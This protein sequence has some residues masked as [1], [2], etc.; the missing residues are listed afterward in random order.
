MNISLETFSPDSGSSF[1]FM[2]NPRLSELF[3]WHFH[4]E[5]EIVWIEAEQGTRH[6]GEHVSVFHQCD[7]VC[8][9]GNI[10][11]LNFDYGIKTPYRHYVLHISAHFLQ[12]ALETVPELGQI[13]DLFRRAAYGLA[14]GRATQAQVKPLIE[15]L[16]TRSGFGLMLSVL[17]LLQ[18]LASATDVSLLH[19]SPVLQRTSEK[20]RQRLQAL[21]RFIDEHYARKISLEEAA[22]VCCLSK[23][24]FC[25]YFKKLSQQTFTEFLNQYRVNQAQRLLL[26]GYSISDTCYAAG[27]ESLSYFN[28]VFRKVTGQSPLA[29]RRTHERSA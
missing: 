11:H 4:P 6:V 19:S 2:D 7:L 3:Y 9:G 12:G 5:L 25:R 14:F 21:Y 22:S 1:R 16:G 13:A 8:I 17:E 26:A 23:A 28:R 18:Q 29:F 27:F 20:E 15:Q 10:P 24:A